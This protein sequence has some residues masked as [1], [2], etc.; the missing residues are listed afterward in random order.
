MPPDAR[1]PQRERG[2]VGIVMQVGR[3]ELPPEVERPDPLAEE[4]EGIFDRLTGN[5]W[6]GF[7]L[8]LRE[9]L[10]AEARDDAERAERLQAPYE[11]AEPRQGGR[12]QES[13]FRLL[14][15]TAS[16]VAAFEEGEWL[17]LMNER[18]A[19][20]ATARLVNTDIGGGALDIDARG[21]DPPSPGIVRPRPR[22]KIIG[23]K[24]A[25]L[26]ELESPQ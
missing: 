10:E 13:P 7:V 25:I 3:I 1:E 6:R 9:A 12:G 23:Q 19:P 26:A 14:G 16:Q 15:L 8:P 22:T 17:D 18:G 21:A 24:R 20:V 4:I 5:R 11:R 2:S